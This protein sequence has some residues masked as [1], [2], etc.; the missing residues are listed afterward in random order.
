MDEY[1]HILALACRAR[2]S[3]TSLVGTM[4]TWNHHAR[5]TEA[6][7]RT[8]KAR[9]QSGSTVHA[10]ISS[11]SGEE[12]P[13]EQ[14]AVTR[15]W[16]NLPS[17]ARSEHR[18]SGDGARPDFEN[19]VVIDGD[20]FWSY[21][22]YSGAMTNDGDQ[23]HQSGIDTRLLDPVSLL[24]ASTVEV[25][26]EA[27]IAGRVGLR[28]RLTPQPRSLLTSDEMHVHWSVCPREVVLDTERGVL[29][30]DTSLLDDE[31]F[32]RV[33]FTEIAFD[34]VIPPE[35]LTFTPPTG[36]EVRN[37]RDV[38]SQSTNRPLHEVAGAASFTVFASARAPEGWTLNANY[39]EANERPAMPEMAHLFY[40]SNEASAQINVN[41]R[42][43]EETGTSDFIPQEC[44][45][46]HETR[47]DREYRLWEPGEEDWPMSRQVVFEE[48]G[49]RVQL[50]G[51]GLDMDA[52]L[53]FAE[54]FA[55]APTEPPNLT[56]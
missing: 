9:N 21:D 43:A 41:Q 26:G 18:Q 39:S 22:S 42:S 34:V 2:S 25:L 28:L 54:T 17:R 49:T 8:E 44:K 5:T 1:A 30:S 12:P 48:A 29:L 38:F 56:T 27:T 45:W 23:S 15:L 13:E 10:E 46:Q 47:D 14:E 53:A 55:P 7:R 36:E 52:L 32:S 6:M 37:V 11:D 50:I 31:P 40:A 3:W 33:E 20:T 24:A 35:R 51:N 4:V 19:T 16:I